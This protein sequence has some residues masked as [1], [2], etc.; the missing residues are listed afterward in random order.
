[1]DDRMKRAS[2]RSALALAFVA[3]AGCGGD[4]MESTVS[5]RVTLDGTPVGPGTVVFAPAAGEQNPATGTI[6]VD[7]AYELKSNRTAGLPAGRYKASVSVFDQAPVAPGE[8]SYEQAKLVT[9]QKYAD[10][11]T[12]DL[13]YDVEP[14]F[15]MIDIE[16][17]SE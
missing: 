15:N 1:M 14:G 10:P 9:P 13:E 7:G 12:S 4:G 8:R 6:Q 2:R 17:K 5:G 11:S 3:W 16:L